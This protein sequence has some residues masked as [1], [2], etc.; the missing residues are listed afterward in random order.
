MDGSLLFNLSG[1]VTEYTNLVAQLQTIDPVTGI[2]LTTTRNGGVIDASGIELEL[3]YRP[4]TEWSLG[5]TAA[6]L[7]AEFGEFGQT[8]PYQ[9]N[10]GVAT[11]FESVNG[12]T[13]GWSPDVVMNFVAEYTMDLAN[14]GTLTPAIMF[15]YSDAY[16]TSNLYSLDPNHDQDSYTKTDL[17]LTWR[18]ESGL[19][20][21]VAYIENLEDEAGLICSN[22]HSGRFFLAY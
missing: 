21:V 7:D 22:Q 11:V 10:R 17:R 13:P 15:A 8:S 16:N 6:F 3:Q 19:Y 18:S 4:T 5:F 14:G 2:V 1:H 12:E 20:A 9:L